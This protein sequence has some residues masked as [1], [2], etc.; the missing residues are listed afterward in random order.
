MLQSELKE[1]TA[2]Y[3]ERKQTQKENMGVLSPDPKA[4]QR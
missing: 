4:R 2:G 1:P 3:R